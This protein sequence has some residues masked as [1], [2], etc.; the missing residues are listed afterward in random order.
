[1][2]S[3]ISFSFIHV[4]SLYLKGEETNRQEEIFYPLVPR[5]PQR[6]NKARGP[7]L[8]QGLPHGGQGPKHLNHH[9]L[10]PTAGVSRK[11]V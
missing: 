10:L 1:M 9:L 7:E 11:L 2:S 8:Q 5:G 6:Q 4:S 3:K